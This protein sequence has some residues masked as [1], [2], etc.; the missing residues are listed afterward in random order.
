MPQRYS[1]SLLCGA[2]LPPG[3]LPSAAPKLG[4]TRNSGIRSAGVGSL[5]GESTGEHGGDGFG[6]FVSRRLRSFCRAR[7][8]A[9]AA[10]CFG[11]FF[12]GGAT[13]G[14]GSGMVGLVC[15]TGTSGG[16]GEPKNHQLRRAGG[17]GGA[18]CVNFWPG[19]T[20]G[21]TVPLSSISDAPSWIRSTYFQ[22]RGRSLHLAEPILAFGQP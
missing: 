10:C 2:L 12:R 13:A 6:P 8:S 5:G 21:G 19:P 22:G 9:T 1:Q 3:Y 17:G 4:I 15:A 14:G 20:P 7:L 16:G 18:M 11:V